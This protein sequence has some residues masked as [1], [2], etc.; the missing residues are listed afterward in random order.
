MDLLSE[1]PSSVCC[2]TSRTRGS[3]PK[4]LTRQTHPKL[5]TVTGLSKALATRAPQPASL[6]APKNNT[7]TTT[8]SE[9]FHKA[10][11]HS[12]ILLMRL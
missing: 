1:L 9:M 3:F 10:G 12:F 4:G 7:S 2:I 8:G 11:V 5:F 6:Q